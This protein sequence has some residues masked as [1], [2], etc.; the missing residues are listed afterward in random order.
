MSYEMK[1]EELPTGRNIDKLLLIETPKE[2]PKKVAK[3]KRYNKG[4]VRYE[5]I[6]DYPLYCLAMVYTLGA[7]KYSVYKDENGKLIKGVDIPYE[8]AHKYELVEDGA[9]NWKLGLSCKETRASITRH[10]KDYDAGEDFDK[11]LGTYHLANAAWGL[12]ALLDQYKTHPELD[13]RKPA[14]LR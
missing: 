13:D 3:G 6:P 2:K 7:H 8:E 12:F 1:F 5:L 11:E 4:K 10:E 14:Y 9:D